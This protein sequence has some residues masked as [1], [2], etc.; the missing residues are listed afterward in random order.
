[1]VGITLSPEQIRKAPQDVRRWLEQEVARTLGFET[2]R[3]APAGAEQ[4]LVACTPA[5]AV[6]VYAAIR[7][8][9]PVTNVFFELGRQGESV[10]RDGIEA[11]RLVDL[12][13]HAR[14]PS[15]D[16]LAT[17]LEVIGE[18]FRQV[19]H[20]AGATLCAID[21]R[22]YCFV[23]SRTQESILGVWERVVAGPELQPSS[24]ARAERSPAPDPY[25]FSE[26]S[27]TLPNAAAHFDGSYPDG[28]DPAEASLGVAREAPGAAE[29]NAGSRP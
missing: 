16:H 3:L 6:A 10:G 15:L 28:F 9:L 8:M 26:M 4:H 27:E 29:S 21:P 14:L 24:P 18:A 20:E 7:T 23:A 12:M 1:M 25:P 19:R 17:C 22:G 2:E 13:R 5:E 11:Y